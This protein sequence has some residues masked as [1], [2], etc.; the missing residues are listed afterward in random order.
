MVPPVRHLWP[1]GRTHLGSQRDPSTPVPRPGTVDV[2]GPT[3][4]MLALHE[5]ARKGGAS[6]HVERWTRR[7]SAPALTRYERKAGPGRGTGGNQDRAA[8]RHARARAVGP[9]C[10]ELAPYPRS[11]IYGH[12]GTG[13]D[14]KRGDTGGP[15]AARP[16]PGRHP[17]HRGQHPPR[18]PISQAITGGLTVAA[19]TLLPPTLGAPLC[20]VSRETTPRREERQ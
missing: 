9:A 7:A 19:P 5:E 16:T 17:G 15:C 13:N 1:C 20:H 10:L 6:A 3:A 11:T 2:A 12:P 14:H 18:A 8:A 4:R